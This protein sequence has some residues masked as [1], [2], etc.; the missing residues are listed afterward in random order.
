MNEKWVLDVKYDQ[1]T[2]DA[3]IELPDQL[4]K[5]AGWNLGDDI[6]WIDNHNGT[7]TMKK[8]EKSNDKEW[9]L[10]DC[11][12]QYRTR[13]MC[14]VPKGKAEWALDTV[15]LKE[16]KEFSQLDIGETIVSHRVVTMQEA[17]DICN[18]DNDYCNT[19]NDEQKVNAFFTKDGEKVQL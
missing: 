8:I 16:A 9:V 4:M 14:E 17:L 11:V 2:D 6:E 18:E 10:V 7:W 19:W 12:Q 1:S 13:Y 15:T 5:E 3:Y